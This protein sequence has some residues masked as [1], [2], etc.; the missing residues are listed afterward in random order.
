MSVPNIN[1]LDLSPACAVAILI[2][3]ASIFV[4]LFCV[5]IYNATN[6]SQ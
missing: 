4:G 1:D 2:S 5:A 3:Y 6:T